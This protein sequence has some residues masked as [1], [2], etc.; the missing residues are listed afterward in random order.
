[1]INDTKCSHQAMGGVRTGLG[2][3]YNI[4]QLC[5]VILRNGLVYNNY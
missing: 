1:M 3:K 2:L 5:G 4:C